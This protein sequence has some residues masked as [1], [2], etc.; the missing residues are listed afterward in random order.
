MP[1]IRPF[2]GLRYDSEVVGDLRQVVAPPYDIIYDEW[3]ERLYE[4]NP[5]NIVRLIKT[6]DEPGNNEENNKYSRARDYEQSWMREGILKLEKRPAIY[7][8]SETYEIEGEKKTRYGF[9]AL[10]K[11]ED[12]GNGIHPHERTLSAPK[13]DRLNLI[14]ATNTNLSQI[15]SIYNDT[16]GEIHNILM[17]VTD[18]EPEVNFTDEQGITRKMWV[19]YDMDVITRIQNIMKDCDI[20]IADGHHRYETSLAF[21]DFMEGKRESDDEPFDYVSMYFS[22]ADAEGMTI[23]PTHRKI[24]RLNGFNEQT[25]I[26]DLSNEF[27]ITCHINSSLDDILNLIK[28]DSDKTNI[29]GVYTKK[30]LVVARLKNPR[31]PKELDVDVLHDNIIEKRLGISKED[32]AQGKYLHFCKSPDHAYDDVAKGKD[33]VS[34]FMNALTSEELFR[35]VLKGRRMPQKSTYFYPKTLSGLVM[36]KIGRESLD[37]HM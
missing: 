7:V 12:F 25:F 33:H 6:K 17:K 36:F 27:E 14:K 19:V 20:I 3:R 26:E 28:K 9:I 30:G 15:F 13:A 8:R 18:T 2:R 4:R 5:Y 32:I 22:S 23:L 10:I 34:F 29:F 21:K 16:G 11:V 24:G 31:V 1:V 35:E 37:N